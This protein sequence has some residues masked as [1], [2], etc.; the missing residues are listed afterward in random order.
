MKI[1]NAAWWR[2][3]MTWAQR[4]GRHELRLKPMATKTKAIDEQQS[5]LWGDAETASPESELKGQERIPYVEDDKNNE[6]E[7]TP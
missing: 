3:R 7:T 4:Q 5:L 2:K 1:D 6:G